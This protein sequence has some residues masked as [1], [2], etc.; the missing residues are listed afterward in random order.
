MVGS[1]SEAAPPADRVPLVDLQ[2]DV[3]PL[4][5]Q[6][7]ALV[8]SVPAGARQPHDREQADDAALRR[9]AR[10]RQV[11]L[12]SLVDRPPVEA[13]YAQRHALREPADAGLTRHNGDHA[14]GAAD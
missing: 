5:A 9:G 11:E 3:N 10:E 7:R 2:D 14:A 6:P 8:E 13:P 1:A 12:R 4:P